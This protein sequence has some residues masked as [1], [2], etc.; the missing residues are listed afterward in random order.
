MF[1]PPA[2]GHDRDARPFADQRGDVLFVHF[3]LQHAAV[4]LQ[5]GKV[6]LSL[7]ELALGLRKL[8]IANFGDAREIAGALVTL[9]FGLEIVDSRL[10]FADF[11]DGILL[12]LPARLFGVRLFA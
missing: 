9:L 3:F 5:F 11:R 6:L 8:A 4:F 2:D 7:F 12:H 10:A 1:R